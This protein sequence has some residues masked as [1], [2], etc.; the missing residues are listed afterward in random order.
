L[1]SETNI[2]KEILGVERNEI[3]NIL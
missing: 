2:K 1:P 3:T